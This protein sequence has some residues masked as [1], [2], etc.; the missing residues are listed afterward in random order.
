MYLMIIFNI[1]IVKY[2]SKIEYNKYVPNNKFGKVFLFII[3]RYL[4]LLSQS[5]KIYKYYQ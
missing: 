2:L 3:H 1:L 4:A 5:V